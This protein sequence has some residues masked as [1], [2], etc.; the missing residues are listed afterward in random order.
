MWDGSLD[1]K[2]HILKGPQSLIL[3]RSGPKN[4]HTAKSKL[5]AV[6]TLKNIVIG[7]HHS[8]P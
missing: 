3:H 5:A 6:V 1:S 8:N 7:I 4:T 2:P